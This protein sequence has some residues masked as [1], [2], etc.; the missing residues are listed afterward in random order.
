MA[1][2]PLRADARRNRELVLKAAKE[3]FAASGFGV[4]LD[5]IA[6]RA[7]V[8]PGTVYRH[9]PTKEALFEAVVTAQ[10]QD[11]VAGA[12]ER[13]GDE[14][15]GAAFFGFLAR[16]GEQAVSKRDLT[17]AIAVPSAVREELHEVL[18]E[19]MR[20]AQRVG[21]VRADLETADVVVLLKGV[22]AGLHDSSLGEVSAERAARL[23]GVLSAGL[24]G[25]GG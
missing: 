10:V 24:R 18:G 21:A 12:R 3:V 7:G 23:F 9:F 2:R 1:E 5:E 17:D 25:S 14:D 8:G 19:L 22:L 13:A 4:P 6:A 11:L 16:L 20:G 15:P